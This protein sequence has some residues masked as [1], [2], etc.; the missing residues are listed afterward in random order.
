MLAKAATWL[1]SAGTIGIMLAGTA[2]SASAQ[3]STATPTPTGP[4][5]PVT[6]TAAPVAA[7]GVTPDSEIIVT[8]TKRSESAS[9]VPLA[10]SVVSGQNLKTAG[11]NNVSDLQNIVP[12]LNIGSGPFGTNL[13]IRGVTST[14]QTSKGELGIAYNI[15]GVFVGRG[16]EQGVA[17]F[18][19]DRIEV[20]RGPQGTLYGRSST[21]GAI[22]VIPAH[23]KLGVVQGYARA[24]LGNYHTRRAEGAMNVPLGSVFAFRAAGSV[25][26]RGGYLHP[27]G[28]ST[29]VGGTTYAIS[30]AGQKNKND[31]VDETGRFS[32]LFQP[33]ADVTGLVVATVG[34][35]GGTGPGV[36]LYD[37]LRSD[38]PLAILANPVPAF[39]LNRFFNLDGKLNVRLGGAQLDLLASRQYFKDHTQ[40]TSTNNPVT[41]SSAAGPAFNLQD[42]QGTFKTTQFEARVSNVDRGRL[43]Y[44]LGANYYFEK[45][46]ESDHNWGAPVTSYANTAS[47][48]NGIDPLNTTTHKSYGIFGQ[49]TFHLT[50][51]LGLLGGLRY[52]HDATQR[53]GTFAVPFFNPA[54]NGPWYDPNGNVC[55]YPNDCVGNPNN[56]TEGDHKF[57]WRVG[58][59]YQMNSANLIYASVATGFKA[60][61]FNDF[62]PSTNGTTAY[63]PESLTA[64]ELGY[65]GR[66]IAGLTLTSSLFYYDYAKDQINGL[67]FFGPVGVLYTQLAPVEI[68][69]WENELSYRVDPATTISG[70]ASLM[71]SKIKQLEVGPTY[72]YQFDWSGQEL[73]R[74]PHFVAT[75]VFS[76]DFAAGRGSVVRLRAQSKYNSGYYLSDTAHAVRFRQKSF[77]RS[78][79][80]VTYAT[81]EDRLTVQLFVEN[82]ENKIQKTASP[83]GY[84]GVSGGPAGNFVP[85]LEGSSASFPANSLTFGISNPRFYGVRVGVKF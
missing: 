85:A 68:Y 45:I 19:I 31:Q 5:D 35:Q 44:V 66:P 33:S 70:S 50:E 74:T 2:T 48:L 26:H 53:V 67:V 17:Y 38:D 14:D 22:N 59:N 3:Q 81:P 82:L 21:G 58:V 8:A 51:Q 52:T 7:N 61:G 32:L 20:L 57:T 1:A 80:S 36:A 16:Q 9:R 30:P 39:Q 10:I 43:D 71:G 83:G 49:A 69:G 62:D 78:D 11:V 23:P 77:T 47:W 60:G 37:S 25:N 4:A 34:H 12:G 76:H 28:F 63:G 27:V 15:D 75:G 55:V 54:T 24:E 6:T 72:P 46:H 65:K 64:Y 13:S 41:N 84:N 79:A 29:V 73:D 42:Y 40:V 56:G 18:D